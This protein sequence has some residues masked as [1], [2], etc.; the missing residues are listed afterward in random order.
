MPSSRKAAAIV[1]EGQAEFRE[2][3]DSA[4]FRSSQAYSR[5]ILFVTKTPGYGGSEKH[6]VELIARL[7]GH[8]VRSLVL[9]ADA[10]PYTER[11]DPRSNESISVRSEPRLKSLWDWLALFRA[12]RPD[13]VVFVYG[14]LNAIPPVAVLAAWLAG[15]RKR[16]SIHHLIP[17]PPRFT[18]EGRWIRN[19]LY[20]VIGARARVSGY[21]CNTTICVSDAVR[22]ALVRDYRF[23]PPRLVTIHN[24][25]SPGGFTPDKKA[26][27]IMRLR[28]GIG[29]HET[30]LVCCSRLSEEK[31]I[32]LLVSAMGRLVNSG[33]VCRC[34]ILGEG[35]LLAAL[36]RQT[37]SLGLE[38]C[39]S[40]EGFQSDVRSYLAAGD[41]FVLP[42]HAEGLPYAV[43][44]A[45]AC[46]LPCIVTNVGGNAEA[47]RQAVDGFVISPGSVDEIVAAV[48]FLITDDDARRGMAQMARARVCDSFDK[49]A[50]NAEFVR[51]ILH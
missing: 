42:S 32:D 30:A 21:L 24:G 19:R 36:E 33:Y 39:V 2:T 3:P 11:L 50:K 23:P 8:G 14:T 7:K 46:G 47:V 20:R 9:C 28:L 16:Y 29:P 38:H 41:I 6:L 31:G 17:P 34:F 15:I 26:R 35:R 10:D 44:E 18:L 25:V 40:F 22:N 49:E 45:M 27:A 37:R 43:L 48:S 1:P 12:E 13:T 4:A 5:T 51:A